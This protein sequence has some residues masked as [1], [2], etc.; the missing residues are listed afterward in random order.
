MSV[1][2]LPDS[3]PLHIGLF[4]AS[5]EFDCERGNWENNYERLKQAVL[6]DGSD[7]VAK[8]VLATNIH[9]KYI[10]DG[11]VTMLGS[12]TRVQ[13][14]DEIEALVLACLPHVQSNGVLLLAAAKLLFFLDRGYR[15][16]AV[17]LA[18]SAFKNSTA[19]ASSLTIVGQM[20]MFLGEFEQAIDFIEQAQNISKEGTQFHYYLLFIKCQ[21]YLAEGSWSKLREALDDFFE[22]VPEASYTVSIFFAS[23]GG[24][25]VQPESEA[26]AKTLSREQAVAILK[27]TNYVYARL[28]TENEPRVNIFKGLTSL[29]IKNFGMD[30]IPN[31]IRKTV[32][33]LFND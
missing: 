1:S 2:S 10:Q 29:M 19:I 4:D 12:D 30:I 18:E 22:K 3:T 26:M 21:T 25:K 5:N 32:P 13:D 28:F 20:R 27:L 7:A 15:R 9:L 24:D 16:L 11:M 31:E 14:E 17:E 33:A 6:D 8:L 23:A